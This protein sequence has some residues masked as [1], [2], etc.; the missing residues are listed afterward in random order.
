LRPS[1][2]AGRRWGIA[3]ARGLQLPQGHVHLAEQVVVGLRN[4][5]LDDHAL[6]PGLLVLNSRL[7]VYDLPVVRRP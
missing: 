3:Q 1:A 5:S 4:G 6:Q 2:G 7:D